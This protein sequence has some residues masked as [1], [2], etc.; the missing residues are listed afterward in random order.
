MKKLILVILLAS[1]VLVACST[2]TTAG[3]TPTIATIHYRSEANQLEVDIPSGWAVAEGPEFLAKPFEGLLAFNSWGQKDFW[4]GQEETQTDNGIA[5]TFGNETVL[6]HIPSDGVYIVLI[7]FAGPYSPPSKYGPEHKQQDLNDL[8]ATKDCREEGAIVLSFYK[9]GTNLNLD[10]YCGS[11]V[12]KDLSSRVNQFIQSWSFDRVPTGNV[13]WASATA[14]D[15]LPP[16]IDPSEFPILPEGHTASAVQQM[17]ILRM[18]SAGVANGNVV[19]VTFS[20]RWNTPTTG[21]VGYDCPPE[22][23]HWW[24]YEAR[25]SGDV[26]LVEEGGA[27]VPGEIGIETPSVTPTIPNESTL[28]GPPVPNPIGDP[29]QI[30]AINTIRRLFGFPDL[31][32]EYIEETL[33]LDSPNMDLY[34]AFYRDSDGRNYY[35]DP[36]SN[37]V[38]E[39]DARDALTL[40]PP[41]ASALSQDQLRAQAEKYVQHIMP[42]FDQLNAGLSYEEGIKGE[43]YFFTWRS[44]GPNTYKNRPFIQ[45]GLHKSGKLFAYYNTTILDN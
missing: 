22:S 45:I 32:L 5:Y 42:N 44:T 20:Y 36:A 30:E 40:I 18:T 19:E 28:S 3:P 38:V 37:Q 21:V 27:A 35:V 29:D 33:M 1:G 9:W 24:R 39:I 34:V 25:P 14:R 7:N 8:W 10:I 26:V 43:Y 6:R 23:C 2:V 15:L 16:S 13:G 12:S 17:D 41:N 11:K 4:V 31:P